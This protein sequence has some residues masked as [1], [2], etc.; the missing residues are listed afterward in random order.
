MNDYFDAH[1]KKN[2]LYL[3]YN[4]SYNDDKHKVSSHYSV[5]NDQEQIMKEIYLNGPVEA[6]FT[7]Y[8]DFP[9]YK[10]GKFVFLSQNFIK[11]LLFYFLF[12]YYFL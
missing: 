6:A 1:L 7:V 12:L 4:V 5:A 3:G 11:S 9:N 8:S 10:S 2:F